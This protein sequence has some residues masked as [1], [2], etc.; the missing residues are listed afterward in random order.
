MELSQELLSDTV[1]Y[2][3][4]AK[5]NEELKRR[6][7][8]QELVSEVKNMHIRKYPALEAQI[9]DAFKFVYDK[10]IIPS[11]RSMQFAGKAIELSES[12]IYNCAYLPIEDR[13][14]FREV[15]FLLMGGT[16]VGFSVQKK[17]IEKLPT[18]KTPAYEQRYIIGDSI[19]GWSDALNRLCK[20]YF[21]GKVRPRF[22]YTDIRAK[23]TPLKKSGGKAPGPDRL[24][25]TL[26][27]I[28][29]IFKQ[30]IG[31]QLYS[32][33]VHDIVC[34]IAN[35][36]VAGGIRDSAMISLFSPDDVHMITAKSFFFVNNPEF[37]DVKDE[38]GDVIVGG[39]EL[40]SRIENDPDSKEYV[41]AKVNVV[42]TPNTN[43]NLYTGSTEQT[44]WLG[45]E[46]LKLL[47]NDGKLAWYHFHPQ[48]GKANNS[49][50]AL[51]KQMNKESFDSFWKFVEES[52]AGEPGIYWSYNDDEG[53]NPCVEIALKPYQFCNLT[54]INAMDIET[55]EEFNA[56][57]RAAAFI[58]TLQAS[59]T[60]FHYLRPVW[61][62]TTQEEAL[63]GVSITGIAYNKLNTLNLKEASAA[64]VTENQRVA[65]ILGIN[66]AARVTCIKPEGS[67]SLAIGSLGA[68]IHAIHDH[69]FIRRVRYNANDNLHKYLSVVVPDLVE[70]DK[71]NPEKGVLSIPVKAPEGAILR[72]ESVMDFLERVKK[73]STDWIMPGHVRGQNSHN[74]SATINIK[75]NE[76]AEVGEWMW[77]NKEFYNGLSCLPFND[78]TYI[79]APL[80]T[81]TEEKYNEMVSK[82]NAINLDEITET[83]DFTDLLAEKAC[84]G[85]ACT[86]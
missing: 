49:A 47:T 12:R 79:Q 54:S 16:G 46:D 56:R 82:L 74:V 23:G 39:R 60:D 11:M 21:E 67:G 38:N 77:K 5:F 50:I 51:R 25:S 66:A 28:E 43:T 10:K 64:A 61:I 17:H 62:K 73:F 4:Y 41:Q 20:A 58:G 44:V 9:E 84:A 36:I 13:V 35:C 29:M 63:L 81:I 59:Y 31:R 15:M 71:F 83:E 68:G 33:E 55:Q 53:T 32:I 69:F 40:A 75:D 65:K 19:E 76:W 22:V 48:R 30:A 86:L 70:L 2:T 18:V 14:A 3:K 42:F 24:K 8:W 85:G 1:I 80:E 57:A 26:E 6:S 7:N 45:H 34:H 78:H 37:F 27:S 52:K 72:H